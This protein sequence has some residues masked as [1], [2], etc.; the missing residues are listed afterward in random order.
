MQVHAQTWTVWKDLARHGGAPPDS[1]QPLPLALPAPVPSVPPG[2]EARFRAL[3][4][5]IK[6]H[7]NYQPYIGVALGIEGAEQ[8]P[9]D[10]ATLQPRLRVRIMGTRAVVAWGWQGWAA[11]LD[12]CEIQVDRSDGQGFVTLICDNTPGYVDLTPFP[13]QPTKWIYR[14]VFRLKDARVGQWSQT[15]SITTPA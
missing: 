9:P 13:A 10:Y 5:Q 8:T 11:F 14:A 1:A 12:Q 6:A 7:R 2:I 15:A 3:V 4:K